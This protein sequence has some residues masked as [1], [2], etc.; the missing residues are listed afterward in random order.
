MAIVLPV[1]GSL[2]WDIALNTALANLQAQISSITVGGAP[3][4]P[5]GGDLGGTYPNPAVMQVNGV[6]VTGTPTSGQTIVATSGTAAAWNTAGASPT[7]AAG[8][9]LSGTYP[10]PTVAKV[11]GTSVPAT[12]TMGQALVA[13]SGTASTW[14]SPSGDLSG[15]F[16]GPT[17]AKIN[18]TSVPAAPSA[19]QVLVATSGTAATWQA[20]PA[21]PPNG[22]AGGDLGSTYPNP[23]VLVTH[24]SAPLPI[25][26]GGT[27]STTQNFVD[28]T[29]NQTI[30][31]VK[32]FSGATN[33]LSNSFTGATANTGV[34][35]SRV[36]GDATAR[37]QM[38]ADG[39][40]NWGLGVSTT[41][42][43][44]YRGGTG[45]LQ[46]DSQFEVNAVSA[47]TTAIGIQVSGDT[48]D[49]HRTTA[50]GTTTI[51]TG[52]LARDVTFGRTAANQF[53]LTTTD[54]AI[55]T[56]GRGLKVAE[57]SNAKMG[58]TG[59]MTAGTITVATSAVNANSRIFLTAQNTGGT[60]G[61]LRVSTI[62][63]GTSFVI[64]STSGT[65]T[66]TVAWFI[67]D[68]T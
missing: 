22:S 6:A 34:V 9:N 36:T 37:F 66:S 43:N 28:L 7:G 33:S 15:T 68:H 5:A 62:T 27:A 45:I 65:D 12:P 42:T 35:T 48:F 64:T 41:D 46:T 2:N 20:A 19:N 18:G 8:G 67:V 31:G 21:S 26:Q 11:N 51:G 24:L 25:A 38:N 23:T 30:A 13:T 53:G 3:T 56:A 4:G 32:T 17:V 16:P 52:A 29:T 58:I 44:L 40:H 59:A 1:K 63:A 55:V 49:R 57:G 14:Q 54:L 39:G 50:D 47:G 60:A 10:N 61:A